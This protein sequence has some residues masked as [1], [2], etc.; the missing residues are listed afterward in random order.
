[1]KFYLLATAQPR[2]LLAGGGAGTPDMSL[3]SI[4]SPGL[5]LEHVTDNADAW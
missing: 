3:L 1:M 2:Q 5:V 4:V